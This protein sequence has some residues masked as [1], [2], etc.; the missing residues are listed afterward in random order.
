MN[1]HD[2]SNLTQLAFYTALAASIHIVE[3]LIMR[4]LPLPFLR[5][6]FS[7]IVIL[8][9]ICHNRIGEAFIVNISK[10]IL[11]G[12]VT[13][14]LLSPSTLLSLTAGISAII[15]MFLVRCLHLGLGIYGISICGA[16]AH[17]LTQL[18]MVRAILIHS[19]KVFVLTPILLSI[20]LI[21]GSII[22]YLT[23]Y[24]DRKSEKA[25]IKEK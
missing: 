2:K 17:N 4:M 15:V 19:D 1:I 23:L 16:I 11:S 9:L 14:T 20:A 5:I 18:A 3:D 10:T 12:I 22:A 24:I 8:Y 6:G 7:N 13:L 25:E 21:S